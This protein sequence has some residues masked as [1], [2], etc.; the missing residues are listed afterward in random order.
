[1][2]TPDASL[3][4]SGVRRLHTQSPPLEYI[5]SRY[6]MRVA[7]FIT[8]FNDSFFPGVGQATVRI[9]ER[10]GQTVEFPEAQTCCGQM[11]FNTGYR[12]EAETLARRFVQIFEPYDAI[13]SPSASCVGMVRE[14]YS[15]LAADAGDSLFS[16][17]TEALVPRVFE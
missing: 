1:M 17:A 12:P 6:V 7:L 10:L 15:Q 9:L 5:Q 16:S 2:S 3:P 13:V 11:H 4:A 14:A 8:C